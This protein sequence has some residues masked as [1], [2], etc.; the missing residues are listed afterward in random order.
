MRL[1]VFFDLPVTTKS[2]RKEYT[3]FRNFLLDNGF[4]MLQYSV[5]VRITRNHDDLQKYIRRV[6][7]NLPPEGKVRCL[8]IT[9]KQYANMIIMLGNNEN[10]EELGSSELIEL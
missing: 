10:E 9:D 5:Y 1:I 7:N 8:S 3:N 2:Q 4:V 6:S